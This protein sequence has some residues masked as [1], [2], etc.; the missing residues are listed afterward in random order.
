MPKAFCLCGENGSSLWCLTS[1]YRMLNKLYT[2]T[3]VTDLLHDYNKGFETEAHSETSMFI[4]L[5]YIMW[6]IIENASF[7]R[8]IIL[9]CSTYRGKEELD[10]NS[11]L[12]FWENSIRYSPYTIT[13]DCAG[14]LF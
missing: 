9:E 13:Y 2:Y 14:V 8:N 3:T 10:F 4:K 11:G 5:E 1:Y 12:L 7:I 6:H